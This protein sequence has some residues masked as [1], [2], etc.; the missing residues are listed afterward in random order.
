MGMMRFAIF[1][2]VCAL[3]A[4]TLPAVGQD[5]P[6]AAPSAQ[7]PSNSDS[8][9]SGSGK[10]TEKKNLQA[11]AEIAAAP[12]KLDLTPDASGNL[13]QAQMQALLRVVAEKDME[14]D[15]RQRDYT[16]TEREVENKLD[17][18]GQTKSTEVKTY[19]V[20]EIYGEQVQRLIE[21]DGNPLDGKEAAKEEEKIQKIIDKRKN[22]SE[23]ERE[24]RERQ[25]EKDRED[26]RSFV[27]DV[28]DAYNFTLVGSETVSGR[29]AWV[30]EGEPRPGFEPHAKD[31][32]YLPKFH[33]RVWIDKD[34]LQ[35]AKLD[36]ECLDTISWG[37]FLARFH[38]GSRFMLEQTRVN[39]EVWLPQHVTFKLDARVALIKG[40]NIDGDQTFRDYKKFRTSAKIVGMGEVK[41]PE[42]KENQK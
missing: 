8:N 20:L 4:W 25:E 33:G 9:V 38:K 40:Y 29:D 1:L 3:A 35:L 16:Y 18:K 32:K 26:E 41:E 21:K 17:G 23:E 36:V 39:D 6:S 27:R 2:F 10:N 34:D 19:E 24:K 15:K 22:E 11:S 37:L 31:A 13:S 12:L 42:E 28:A 30:I 14:N 5:Q 7:I